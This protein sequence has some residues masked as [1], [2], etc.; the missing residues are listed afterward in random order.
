MGQELTAAMK[1][2]GEEEVTVAAG[3]YKAIA[4]SMEMEFM[5]QKIT[6][7]SWFAPNV[8]LVKQKFDLAGTEGTM[9]LKE[10]KI[11]K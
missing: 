1:N 4:V 5:G 3:K 10:V 6:S 2:E 9:E 8:G 7:T 11:V